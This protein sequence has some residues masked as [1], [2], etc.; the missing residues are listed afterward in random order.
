M[1][2]KGTE[3]SYSKESWLTFFKGSY[4]N[5]FQETELN[6]FSCNANLQ[7]VKSLWEF[8]SLLI[9]QSCCLVN[10]IYGPTFYITCFPLTPKHSYHNFDDIWEILKEKIHLYG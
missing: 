2:I 3:K 5:K 6:I 10:V 9:R 7:T 8:I 1:N 4:L